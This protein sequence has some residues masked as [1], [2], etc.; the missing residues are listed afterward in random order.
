VGSSHLAQETFVSLR[1]PFEDLYG[2]GHVAN[3]S[4]FLLVRNWDIQLTR[5]K[6]INGCRYGSKWTDY[7][8]AKKHNDHQEQDGCGHDEQDEG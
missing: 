7:F 8:V 1:V 6:P 2:P 3:L 4:L 5:G